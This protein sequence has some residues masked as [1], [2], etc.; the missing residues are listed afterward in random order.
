MSKQKQRIFGAL[1]VAAVWL[2]LAA[3]LW[4]G[5]RRDI[6]EAERRKLEQFP[7]LTSQTLLDGRFMT[8]FEAFTQ[9][10]FPL[11]EGF[12]R[13]KAG[14]SYG[15][16]RRLDNNGIYLSEGSAARLEYPLNANSVA[17]AVEKFQRIYDLYL[18]DSGGKIIFSV[19]PDKG[20][21]LAAPNGCPAMDYEAMFSAIRA[22][23]W[24]R[25]VDLTDTLS[26]GSYY[27][28][29]TH[30]RQETLLPAAEK[31]ARALGVDVEDDY[32]PTA[33]E[34]PFYGVYCGQAA[35]PLEPDT[36]WILES[37]TISGC[38]VT[39]YETGE[40]SGVYDFTK[41]TSQ[42]LYDVFLSGPAAALTV[43]NPAAMT[44]RELIVFRDSFAS[45]L[46]PLLLPGY[47]K[48]TLLD[49]RYVPTEYLSQLVTFENQDVLF[50]YSTLVLN[51][52]AMLK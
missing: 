15:V 51:Q 31:I 46:V 18:K 49:I 41:L 33:L 30:W 48:V 3:A 9:D 17:G 25:Y 29:D 38:T 35:L 8:K 14:F 39:N 19:V 5:P 11:R 22:I 2:A 43:D 21:Y 44:D 27:A 34:R 50:L 10:Q 6:S 23:P 1:A 45:S 28:T 24:V 47:S 40:T 7:P 13:L 32:R 42:D 16:L 4:F 12:R 26:A 36:L 37:D 20:Y 52:S